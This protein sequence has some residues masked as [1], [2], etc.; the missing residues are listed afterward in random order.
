MDACGNKSS[1]TAIFAIVD[2]TDPTLAVANS[3]VTVEC[4]ESTEVGSTGGAA[5]ASDLGG[6]V[7]IDSVD[8]P[9]VTGLGNSV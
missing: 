5:T 8:G 6:I 3:T 9:I 2:T 1:T 7:S 4:G